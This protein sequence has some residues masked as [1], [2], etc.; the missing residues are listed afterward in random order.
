MITIFTPTYNREKTLSRLYDSLKNQ[1]NKSF[2]WLIVDDGSNDATESLI[3]KYI[4]DGL[5]K[6]KYYKQKNSGKHIAINFGVT[7]AKYDWFFIVDSDDLLV[8]NAADI[9]IKSLP[10]C[11]FEKNLGGI[12]FRKGGLD[13]SL[14][15]D[16]IDLLDPIYLHPID[17]SSLFKADL[18]YI[19]NTTVLKK[20]PFPQ[21]AGEK[22]VPEQYIWNKIGDSTDIRYY[23]NKIIYLCEYLPDGYS[24]NFKSNLRMNPQGFK[25]FYQSQMSRDPSIAKKLKYFLRV[26][27]CSLYSTL[28]RN[29]K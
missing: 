2:E 14:L 16:S 23:P 5:I 27:Q 4:S 26:I 11:N 13:S 17:A 24:N 15:G 22:F 18:A 29:I 28:N 25:L 10:G 3:N 20:F 19:F 7:L 21:I 6:I 1:S 12:C 8:N 9:I